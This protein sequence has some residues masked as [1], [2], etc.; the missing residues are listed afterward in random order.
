MKTISEVAVE[1][2]VS[3]RTIRYY[4]EL[5][6][7]HSTRTEGNRRIYAKKECAKL[8]LIFRGKRFGFS[9]DEIKEMVLLFD[10]DRTGVAQ[11]ERTISYGDRRIKQIDAT[12]QELNEMREELV[13]LRESFA[14]KLEKIAEERNYD[15]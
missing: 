7:I 15:E 10:R 4:E 5:G 8:K 13:S 2:D 11:L 1:F 12:I 6:L 9:L 3:T 14:V